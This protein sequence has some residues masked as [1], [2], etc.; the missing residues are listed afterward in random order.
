MKIRM[1]LSWLKL[2]LRILILACVLS[3]WSVRE[4]KSIRNESGLSS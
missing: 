3:V 4:E 1:K 2:G